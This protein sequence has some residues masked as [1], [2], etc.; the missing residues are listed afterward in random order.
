M[1]TRIAA[2]HLNGGAARYLGLIPWLILVTALV[3]AFHDGLK[4]M[5]G[6]WSREEY[7]HGY[8]IPVIA[9]FMVWRLRAQL[10]E[11]RWHGTW[12]GVAVVAFA[13]ALLVLGE[14]STL[15]IIIQYAFLLTLAGLVLALAGWSVLRLLTAPLVYLFFMIPLPN[16]FYNTL[17]QKLQLVSS[18]VGVAF[19]RLFDVSVFLEGNVIDL[20]VYQLQV[21]EACSGLR[22]LFPLMSFGFLCAYLF[23]APLWQRALVFL[24]AIPLTVLMN[25]FRVGVIG[26]LVN[27]YGTAQAEG[28][29]HYFEGWVIFM[30][31]VALLFAEMW[32][33]TR[34]T[35]PGSSFRDIFNVD[36]GRPVDPEAR[37]R[38]LPPPQSVTAAVIGVIVVTAVGLQFITHREEIVP[39]RTRFSAFP[40]VLDEWRGQPQALPPAIVR[41]LDVDDYLL[42]NYVRRDERVPVNLY[43]AYYS[44]QRKGASIHSPRSCLPGHDWEIVS[45]TTRKIPE[46]AS[47]GAPLAVNR[48]LISQ[49]PARQ[50]VYYWFEQRGRQLTSEYAVKWYLLWD[51]IELNRTDG[52]LVRFTTPIPPGTS[53][54]TAEER[55]QEFLRLAYPKLE[56]YIP[57]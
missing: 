46:V 55:M 14:L 23:K 38:W 2:D 1:Q 29:L 37:A 41:G 42:T 15:Y 53:V 4:E 43:V 17:S 51:A 35:Q 5:A 11:E 22:Y 10:V 34:I 54:D 24:S 44:S 20:G 45:L 33:L 48:V 40:D 9:A 28:F 31:C 30:S 13:M 18:A 57:T 32:L 27:T 50:L 12:A 25:S 49:G 3:V 36:S 7:S 26:I 19:M 21:V 39:E 52:A 16:F 47:R 8:L 6:D 56:P